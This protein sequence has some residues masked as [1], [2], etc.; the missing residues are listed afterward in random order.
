MGA[1]G[2][3]HQNPHPGPHLLR[4]SAKLLAQCER[5]GVHGV[6]AADLDDVSKLL[7][8]GSQGRL[9]VGYG[10]T[11]QREWAARLRLHR[12]GRASLARGRKRCSPLRRLSQT[13]AREPA[14][15]PRPARARAAP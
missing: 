3:L 9:R 8:L 7:G 15:R 2:L 10:Y 4:V 1:H 5:R 14:E 6:G 12:A 13:Q 11:A